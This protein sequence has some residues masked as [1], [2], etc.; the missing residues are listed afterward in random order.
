M[1]AE[2]P[3]PLLPMAP[4]PDSAELLK[5]ERGSR[6]QGTGLVAA[7]LIGIW[8]LQRVWPR[9]GGEPS[10]PS[11]ALL[12]GLGARLE[13][14]ATEVPSAALDT[15]RPGSARALG[16]GEGG[17]GLVNAVRLGPLELRFEGRARLAGSRPLLWFG[18]DQLQLRFGNQVV[19]QRSLPPAAAKRQPFFALIGKGPGWLAARGRGGGLAL[20]QL[21]IPAQQLG[22]DPG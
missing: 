15:P 9:Q 17:L 16:L 4:L 3:V 2:I 5:L 14:N 1:L 7:D 21:Q 11:S 20:W 8:R 6:R 18:F 19:L 12:R 10:G 22:A 13:I